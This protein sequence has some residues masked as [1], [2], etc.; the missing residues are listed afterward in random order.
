MRKFRKVMVAFD[1]SEHS[2]DALK[3][4]AQLVKDLDAE[5][6]V[7]SVINQRDIDA[8]EKVA[9]EYQNVSVEHYVSIQK[10]ERTEE[11]RKALANTAHADIPFKSVFRIGVPFIELVQAIKDEGADLMVMGSKGRSNLSGVLFGTTAEK[12]FR[13][14]PVPL[15]SIRERS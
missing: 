13:R 8:V 9:A 6:S 3:Y 5:L 7:V 15:L 10:D 11:I 14:C 2:A 1:R 12:M 4:A